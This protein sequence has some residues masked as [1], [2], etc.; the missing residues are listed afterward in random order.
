MALDRFVYWKEKI[1]TRGQLQFALE[2]YVRDLAIEVKWD[3]D[4]FFVTLPGSCSHPLARLSDHSGVR[5][6][7]EEKRERWFE[8][9]MAKDN[10]DVLTRQMDEVTNNIAEGFAQLCARWWGGKFDG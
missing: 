5:A 10:I 9:C 6:M 8:V 1:P 3:K 2:D 4:R 7:A